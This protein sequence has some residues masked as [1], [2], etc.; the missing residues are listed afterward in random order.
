MKMRE[1][2]D[3]G[4]EDSD[5]YDYYRTV[6]IIIVAIFIMIN[7]IFYQLNISYLLIRARPYISNHRYKCFCC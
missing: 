6:V 7:N 2:E 3:E 4:K 1:A 5:Y